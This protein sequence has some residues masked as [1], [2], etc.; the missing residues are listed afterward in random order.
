MLWIPLYIYI[1]IYIYIYSIHLSV[2]ALCLS[3]VCL[4]TRQI[5]LFGSLSVATVSRRSWIEMLESNHPHFRPITARRSRQPA[6]QQARS[7]CAALCIS[8]VLHSSLLLPIKHQQLIHLQYI[9]FLQENHP[10]PTTKTSPN[11]NHKRLY[12]CRS[13]WLTDWLTLLC[14]CVCVLARARCK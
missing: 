1:Y 4:I 10:F 9:P 11:S 8:L 14:V 5:T 2:T 7:P 3:C 6:S 13:H 12:R